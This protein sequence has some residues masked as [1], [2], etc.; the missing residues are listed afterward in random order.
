M[1]LNITIDVTEQEL[2]DILIT[3]VEGGSNYWAIFKSYS[4]DKGTVK[5]CE[6][7]QETA[8]KPGWHSIGPLD[9]ARGLQLAADNEPGTFTHWHG[10]RCG[11]AGSCDNIFQLALFGE[12]VYG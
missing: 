7:D 3:A 11:D 12:V 10:D 9:I 2:I 8:E 4:C 6:R 5:V 1:K